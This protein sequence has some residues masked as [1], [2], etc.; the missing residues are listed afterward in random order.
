MFAVL[1][2]SDYAFIAIIV[3]VFAGGATATYSA[4]KPADLTRL[5]RLECK[6]DLVMK[7]LGI[8][9]SST[10]SPGELSVEVKALANDPSQKIQ[11]I[12]LHREQSGL[13]LKEAKDAVEAYIAGR[14]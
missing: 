9:Y 11:A 8:E 6:I 12:K 1:E 3:G 7:H 14:G 2:F 4:I 5:I 13:G 10:S